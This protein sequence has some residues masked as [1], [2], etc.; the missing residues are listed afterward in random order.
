M[1]EHTSAWVLENSTDPADPTAIDWPARQARALIPY[2][3]VWG[4]PICPCPDVYC[5]DH[6]GYG[7]NNMRFW[8]ENP[9]ADALVTA[10]FRGVRY[11]LLI[12]RGDGGGWAMP[13]GRVEP[14]EVALMAAWRELTEETGLKE[15]VFMPPAWKLD[16]PRWVPDPRGSMEA[17]AVTVV[18]RCDLGEV[19]ALP[20]VRGGDDAADA[21]WA[22]VDMLADDPTIFPAHREIL[23]ALR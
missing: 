14:G 11:V 3:V 18:A 23:G 1:I 20:E 16:M 8:G 9:M 13:G 21:A 15:S 10:A 5:S 2:K 12:E 17:W 4:R 6:V 22:R 7:R 19:D